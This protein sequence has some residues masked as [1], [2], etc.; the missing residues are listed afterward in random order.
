MLSRFQKPT[1]MIESMQSEKVN[2]PAPGSSLVSRPPMLQR[3]CAC[4]ASPGINGD[5]DKCQENRLTLQRYSRERSSS[6]LGDL[7]TSIGRPFISSTPPNIPINHDNG[8]GHSF[9]L[10]ESRVPRRIQTK[11][12]LSQPGDAAEQEAEQVAKQITGA[13]VPDRAPSDLRLS[14]A[15]SQIQRAA[16]LPSHDVDAGGLNSSAAATPANLIV[17]DNA[18][19]IGAGQMRKGQFLQLLH[20]EIFAVA[21]S[22]LP[23]VGRSAESCPYI[24]NWIGYGYTRDST[25]VE[26]FVRRFA[27]AGESVASAQDYI[28]LV[29]ARLRQALLVWVATG[30]I[31]GVPDDIAGELEATSE[32]SA[33]ETLGAEVAP[34]GGGPPETA[35]T[36]AQLK[37]IEG[38]RANDVDPQTVQRQLGSGN[39]LDG[40]VKS[41]M[42]KAFGYNFS[43]VRVHHD[44][45]AAN[46]S[47]KLNARAFTVG[48]NVA[49]GANEYKPGNPIGDALLAH[50]LAH[51]VQQGSA[52]PAL[53]SK[54]TSDSAYGSLEEDADRSAV[55]AVVA[56]WGG[57]KSQLASLGGNSLPRLRSGLRLSRCKSCLDGD[58][59]EVKTEDGTVPDVGGPKTPD[60]GETQQQPAAPSPGTKKC[61]SALDPGKVIVDHRVDPSP[62]IIEKPGDKVKFTVTFACTVIDD[63][64]S[65]FID[66]GGNEFTRVKQAT[67]GKGQFVREWDGM[68]QYPTIGTYL[69]DDGNN[70]IH[71]VEPMKYAYKYNAATKKSD[72]MM[73]SGPLHDSP[74]VKVAART[75]KGA[76]PSHFHYNA[77]NVDALADIIESE[78]GI[79]EL[80]EKKAVAWSVR[81][82]MIRLGT[83]DVAVARDHFADQHGQPAKAA[84]KTLADEIL[85]KPMSDDTT[86]GAIKWYSPKGMFEKENAGEQVNCRGG[87]TTETDKEGKTHSVC[88]PDWRKTMTKVTVA[89]ARDWFIKMYKL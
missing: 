18:Q 39:S 69:V 21:D 7:L 68:K 66:P 52:L 85:K 19:E 27:L 9:G 64:F 8:L 53:A 2:E 10:V 74:P 36:T 16:A 83:G 6:V 78:I 20:A 86:G 65:K 62:A 15:A 89:G 75:H 47:T 35:G 56:L 88:S 77:A 61:T 31:S 30:Q 57:A 55:G 23:T 51:V 4:G 29:G 44:A 34:E 70:Y 82:Q 81:N 45:V 24:T 54:T 43:L 46:L 80:D 12:A 42:E 38:G 13:A 58:E 71:R 41:R 11:L 26:T 1:A 67:N 5:C 79:G 60:A 72:D 48:N 25:Y 76:G 17:E 33:V 28:G 40:N 63:A 37:A 32:M 22:I 87:R 49:F 50:E 14:N 59:K 3:K 73:T 84:T